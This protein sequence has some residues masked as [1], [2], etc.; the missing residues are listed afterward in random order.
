MKDDYEDVK[1]IHV[2]KRLCTGIIFLMEGRF[3]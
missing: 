3:L 1:P 2:V